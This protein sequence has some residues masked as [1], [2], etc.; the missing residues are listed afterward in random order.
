MLIDY[1]D[2]IFETKET[3]YFVNISNEFVPIVTISC[4]LVE[5]QTKP[6]QL[7]ALSLQKEDKRIFIL[8]SARQNGHYGAILTAEN[9]Y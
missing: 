9:A 3:K 6:L 5:C 7:S 1:H 4:C 2:S 8:N